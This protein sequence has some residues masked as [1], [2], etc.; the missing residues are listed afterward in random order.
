MAT[1]L[2][3]RLERY[4]QLVVRMSDTALEISEILRAAGARIPQR[5][6]STKG[7]E[8]IAK[9]A[10]KRWAAHRRAKRAAGK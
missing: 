5:R 9:A 3:Q 7:R 4:K 2:E 8:A 10:R 6:L 1:K